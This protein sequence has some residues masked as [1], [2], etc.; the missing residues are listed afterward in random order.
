MAFSFRTAFYKLAPT[1][2]TSGDGE[3]VLGTLAVLKDAAMQRALEALQARMPSRVG[4]S[5]LANMSADRGI[6]QGRSEAAEHYVTRLKAWRS[7]RGHRT[8][9]SAFALLEQWSEYWGGM[10]STTRDINATRYTRDAGVETVQPGTPWNW[11]GDSASWSRFWLVCWTLPEVPSIQPWPALLGA[12]G[13]S[14]QPGR[15]YTLGQ[16]GVTPDDIAALQRLFTAPAWKPAGTFS[17]FA[18]I[19][20]EDHHTGVTPIA[21]AGAWGTVL[22][23]GTAPPVVRFWQLTP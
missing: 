8:R 1:W 10:Y 20:I 12:W 21:P 18:V 2:L 11:D 19:V 15:G 5:A 14:L 16:Q 17:D 3:L 13:N 9:G 6:H 23:R 7:P 22:G 4:A